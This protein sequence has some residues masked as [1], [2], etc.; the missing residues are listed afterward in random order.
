MKYAFKLLLVGALLMP[1]AV[2]ADDASET[3][4]VAQRVVD[5]SVVPGLDARF[6]RMIGEAVAKQ[7]TDKQAQMRAELT[8]AA[9][10]VRENLVKVFTGYY[11]QSFSSAELKDLLAFYQGPLGQK[12]VR[13]G[14]H[15]P[16][17]VNAA[18]E[19]QIMKLIVL[20]PSR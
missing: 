8:A 9:A 11:V 1:C 3:S 14:E 19:Q 17:D 20:L 15:K 10:G 2:L 13:V 12:A 18:I 4:A 6:D 16:P 5:L 7:P